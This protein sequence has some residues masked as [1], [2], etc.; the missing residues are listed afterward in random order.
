VDKENTMMTNSVSTTTIPLRW[1]DFRVC[2]VIVS[3]IF[4]ASCSGPA[5]PD[6]P[7]TESGDSGPASVATGVLSPVLITE[8]TPVDSDDPAIW[9]DP[10]DPGKSLVL[11]TDK[12]G[13]VVV[14]DLDGR[15]IPEKTVTG[16]QRMNNIDVEYGFTLG[17]E[18]ID[19]AVA[20]ERP[21]SALRV[22]RL[23]D[24]TAIDNGGITVFE[25]ET[26]DAS[27][28]MGI[29]LYKRPADGTIFA[30]VS[31]KT[32][33][34][35]SYLWQYRLDDDGAGNVVGAKVREFGTF[36]DATSMDEGVAEL[37]EI[38]S[39]AVDDALGYLYYSDELT[40]VRKYHADPDAPEANVELAL[41]ATDGFADQREGI[42]IYTVEDG[43]GYILVSDQQGNA[44]RIYT[45]EGSP[46]DPHDHRFVKSVKVSTNE[47]DGSEITSA[48]LDPRFPS[49]LFVAMSDNRTFHYYSWDDIAGDDLVKAPNGIVAD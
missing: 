48:V 21:A 49:G 2:L 6:T 37:G 10:E 45:R 7:A 46:G 26:G 16:L 42:S 39:I 43:T 18:T 23:P 9:I 12:G 36:S 33:P 38:E 40:G 44:F 13:T 11:G 15:I 14:F 35:G 27:L 3:I 8:Q 34:S 30:V 22:F 1:T 24:M 17:G 29:A 4:L 31:R 19:I 41:L 20:T 47:S 5:G 32:G 25:G 28:P